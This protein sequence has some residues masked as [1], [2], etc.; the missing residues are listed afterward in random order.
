M[1]V[2]YATLV[3]VLALLVI[4]ILVIETSP[5]KCDQVCIDAQDVCITACG[6]RP[7]GY[8]TAECKEDYDECCECIPDCKKEN[9][10]C[11]AECQDL[12]DPN[13][14]TDC[15]NECNKENA[16]C[17]EECVESE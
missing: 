16:E 17:N 10:E 14:I 1:T 5:P 9:E 2:H 15:T 6:L 4:Q 7:A 8:C 13:E 11:L 12:S 3:S